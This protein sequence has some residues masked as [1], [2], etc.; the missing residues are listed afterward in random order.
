MSKIDYEK[1]C[2]GCPYKE[3]HCD[4][5]KEPPIDD[6]SLPCQIA[7]STKPAE[8]RGYTI[9]KDLGR[10]SIGRFGWFHPD[11]ASEEVVI[12]G[13]RLLVYDERTHNLEGGIM[14]G[15]ELMEGKEPYNFNSYRVYELS[16]RGR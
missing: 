1:I 11:D 2:P 4:Q 5:G 12:E 16:A 15:F 10:C 8:S 6:P 14:Y 9:M 7:S 3:S 13:K